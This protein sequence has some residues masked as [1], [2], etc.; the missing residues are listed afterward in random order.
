MRYKRITAD[1]KVPERVKHA[2]ILLGKL[3]K[4]RRRQPHSRDPMLFQKLGELSGVKQRLFFNRIKRSS[5]QQCTEDFEGSGIK[6]D[7]S[8]LR[9]AV[10]F[11]NRHI[12]RMFDEPDDIS[13]FNHDAFRFAGR[14]GCIHSI[15]QVVSAGRETQVCSAYRFIRA[16]IQH[17]DRDLQCARL[18]Q[19]V[20]NCQ[21]DLNRTVFRHKAETVLRKSRINRHI[22]AACF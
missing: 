14:S 6:A 11:M 18:F 13:V 22:C 16:F 21:H 9:H 12:I 7:G 20:L 4:Q 19:I 10:F 1:D 15:R 8:R 3:V 5:V 2:G 17:D